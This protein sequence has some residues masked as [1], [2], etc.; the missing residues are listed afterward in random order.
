MTEKSPPVICEKCHTRRLHPV[1]DKGHR[2]CKKCRALEFAKLSGAAPNEVRKLRAGYAYAA[3]AE[4]LEV[5]TTGTPSVVRYA[6]AV[7][8]RFDLP[9]RKNGF[10]VPAQKEKQKRN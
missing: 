7:K 3:V 6:T 2:W 5:V 9:G 4:L 8:Y 10:T 1:R